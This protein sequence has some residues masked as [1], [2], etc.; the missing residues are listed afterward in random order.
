MSEKI[1]SSPLNWYGGKGGSVQRKLLKEILR[2]I[3]NSSQKKFVD[4]FGGS[5]I[6]SINT[7]KD[8]R[9]YNDINSNLFNF[10]NVLKE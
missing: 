9:V 8:L 1:V 6:V 5:G 10:F 7:K 4:V 2:Y 3:N